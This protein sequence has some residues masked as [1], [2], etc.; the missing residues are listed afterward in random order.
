MAKV[1]KKYEDAYIPLRIDNV[2][3]MWAH[4]IQPDTAFGGNK[5]CVDIVLPEEL[6]ADMEA[7]G[8]NMKQLKDKDKKV[9]HQ[10]VVTAKREVATSKGTNK[11]PA[12]FGPDGSPGWDKD[13]GNGSICNLKLTA[14]KWPVSSTITLYVEQVQVVKHVE[15]EAGGGFEDTTGGAPK[16]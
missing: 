5:W 3:V 12:L 1:D 7:A 14:R 10:N 4:L 13:I 9:I 8:F 6:A 11:P 16:F 2:E 15:F